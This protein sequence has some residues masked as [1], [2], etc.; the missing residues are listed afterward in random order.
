MSRYELEDRGSIPG[1]DRIFPLKT[2]TLRPSLG[3]IGDHQDVKP[4]ALLLLLRTR[5]ALPPLP[6]KQRDMFVHCSPPVHS[7]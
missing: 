4:N 7:S 2:D 1:K 5:A 6:L 3:P